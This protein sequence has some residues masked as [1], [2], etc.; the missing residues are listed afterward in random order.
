MT[1]RVCHKDKELAEFD[2]DPLNLTEGIT[3]YCTKN[4]SPE[5]L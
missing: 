3:P 4:V 5:N 2:K 1:C